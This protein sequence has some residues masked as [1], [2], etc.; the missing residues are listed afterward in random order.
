MNQTED[1]IKRIEYVI[2]NST[3]PHLAKV[4][5]NLKIEKEQREEIVKNK[6]GIF[7]RKKKDDEVRTVF[8]KFLMKNE[9]KNV[10][11]KYFR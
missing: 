2:E 5:E 9:G 1:N 8:R 6:E 7:V 3:D 10:R 4:K 11:D